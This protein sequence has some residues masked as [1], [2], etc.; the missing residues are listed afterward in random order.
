MSF[1][2]IL[3]NLFRQT[4]LL[5]ISSAS[6][7]YVYARNLLARTR[8]N[9]DPFSV[10]RFLWAEIQMASEDARRALPMLFILCSSSRG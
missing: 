7:L 6:N 2:C 3:N 8:R 4:L 5:D 10:S 9:G 1:F